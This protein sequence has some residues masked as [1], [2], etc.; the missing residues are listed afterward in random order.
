MYF[1]KELSNNNKL[2]IGSTRINGNYQHKT[3]YQLKITLTGKEDC[4]LNKRKLS[5][6]SGSFLAVNQGSEFQN[7]GAAVYPTYTFSICYSESF[8]SD[9]YRSSVSGDD[10]LLDEPFNDFQTPQFVESLYPLKG[11][12][13]YTVMHLKNKIVNGSPDELLINDYLHHC[14]I[15]Q[16]KIC[17][18][19]I[20]KC[21]QGLTCVKRQ[22]RDEIFKRLMLA[23][24]F[25][26]TNYN[27]QLSVEEIARNSCLSVN[28]FLR[29]FKEAYQ[30]SPHQFLTQVRLDQA[31]YFLR[32]TKLPISEIVAEIGFE[33]SSAFIRLFKSRFAVTPLK[34]RMA[35]LYAAL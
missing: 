22:T 5:I 20:F 21:R 26:R 35:R 32:Q 31:K 10:R 29:T 15:N 18:K 27:K 25:M 23:K 16:H 24:E 11:D 34:Y 2:I 6:H 12:L 4:L 7:L 17:N 1:F 19:E 33:C 30:L 9:F 13:W 14:L 28:H 8:L 3:D